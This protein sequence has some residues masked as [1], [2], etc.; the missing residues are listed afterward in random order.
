VG[1]R[2]A[3]LWGALDPASL[4]LLDGD[5]E[6]QAFVASL[7]TPLKSVLIHPIYTLSHVREAQA[8][9]R[10]STS[11]TSATSSSQ[12]IISAG[13]SFA[14]A[15]AGQRIHLPPLML[16][17]AEF[18]LKEIPPEWNVDPSIVVGLL[19]FLLDLLIARL[20]ERLTVHCLYY[21]GAGDPNAVKHEAALTLQ[22]MDP[23]I[24]PALLHVFP[25]AAGDDKSYFQ[26]SSLPGGIAQ[27]YFCNPVTMAA[28]GYSCF[29]N[30]RVWFLLQALVG[31]SSPPKR[32]RSSSSSAV[33]IALTLA[34]ATYLDIHCFVFV[35]PI[36][37]W[38]ADRES[39]GVLF[40]IFNATLQGLSLVLVGSKNYVSTVVATHLHTF[41]LQNMQPS[42]TTL[43]YL[44]MQVFQRFRVYFT[45]LLAGLPFLLIAPTT[46]RLN[47]YPD[48]LVRFFWTFF[49]KQLVAPCGIRLT[50]LCTLFSFSRQV[51]IFWLL[52]VL[53]R[54]PGTLYDLNIAYCF[55]LMNPRSLARMR[56][57]PCLVAVCA[58]PI[59]VSLYMVGYWMWMEPNT[60]EANYLYFQ[61]LAYG[62][63]CAI[64]FLNFCSASIRRD[65]ALRLT[66]ARI[67]KEEAAD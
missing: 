42:L 3:L 2:L 61:C 25:V 62:V 60:G 23:K 38:Q 17:A 52:G 50:R 56:A 4:L 67:R 44:G 41:R 13:G 47:E 49:Q 29:Q 35:I 39:V 5:L 15:Y 24:R 21:G 9:R 12:T 53:F 22:R 30:L 16:A 55:M 51:A 45:I 28:G 34:L 37:I 7:H 18:V 32:N 10:L 11:S 1:L 63:F 46:V 40:D 54:P 8:I 64:L 36:T 31:A 43:W 65:K 19:I 14:D 59:P 48:V 20:L 6:E 33:W 66:E 26:W 58:I 27:L 57:A